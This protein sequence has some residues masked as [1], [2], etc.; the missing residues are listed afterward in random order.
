MNSIDLRGRNLILEPML[1]VVL[2]LIYDL[3]YR[4]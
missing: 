3:P 4:Y 1:T 2:K